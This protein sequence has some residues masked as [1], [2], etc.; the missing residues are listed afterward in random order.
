MCD[1]D[2]AIFFSEIP[3]LEKFFSILEGG[4]VNYC[5]VCLRTENERLLVRPQYFTR[6]ARAVKI[7]KY[8]KHNYICN[9]CERQAYIALRFYTATRLSASVDTIFAELLYQKKR[10]VANVFSERQFRNILWSC[11]VENKNATPKYYEQQLRKIHYAAEYAVSKPVVV[12]NFGVIDVKTP[13]GKITQTIACKYGFKQT[14]THGVDWESFLKKRPG[15]LVRQATVGAQTD[16]SMNSMVIC[17][18]VVDERLKD[19]NPEITEKVIFLEEEEEETP[20]KIRKIGHQSSLEILHVT[21]TPKI[22]PENIIDTPLLVPS[23]QTTPAIPRINPFPQIPTSSQQCSMNSSNTTFTSGNTRATAQN[24]TNPQK[25]IPVIKLIKLKRPP[26]TSEQFI[27]PEKM[28]PMFKTSLVNIQKV[29]VTASHTSSTL[30]NTTIVSTVT[31]SAN[32]NEQNIIATSQNNSISNVASSTSMDPIHRQNTNPTS[33]L[34]NFNRQKLPTPTL[35]NS[36]NPHNI[37]TTP[38]NPINAQ[39]IPV[40]RNN[41]V[42]NTTS[43]SSAGF[44]YRQN[45]IHL[46]NLIP[47][48]QN[49]LNPHKISTENSV[50]TQNTP[51]TTPQNL[52]GLVNIIPIVKFN[53][54]LNSTSL[55]ISSTTQSIPIVSSVTSCNRQNNV[56]THTIIPTSQ[57]NSNLQIPTVLTQNSINAQAMST[58]STHTSYTNQNNP[59]VSSIT[60]RNCQNKINTPA[61]SQQNSVSARTTPYNPRTTNSVKNT[62]N[63]QTTIPTPHLISITQQKQNSTN[64]QTIPINPRGTNSV[65]NST[66][67]SQIIS[68][69]TQQ[70]PIKH[71]TIPINPHVTSSSQNTCNTQ[72]VFITRKI[73]RKVPSTINCNLPPRQNMPIMTPATSSSSLNMSNNIL[74]SQQNPSN[75]PILSPKIS[76]APQKVSIPF[77]VTTGSCGNNVTIPSQGLVNPQ[78]TPISPQSTPTTQNAPTSSPAISFSRQNIINAQNIILTIPLMSATPQNIPITS[79]ITTTAPQ[80]VPTLCPIISNSLQNTLNHQNTI[81]TFPQMSNT[82][83]QTNTPALQNTTMPS[84]AISFSCQNI[85]NGQN[86]VPTL[87]QMTQNIPVILPVSQNI[88][89]ALQTILPAP[90]TILPLPQTTL[91]APQTTLPAPQNTPIP[92]IFSASTQNNIPTFSKMIVNTQSISDTSNNA[93]IQRE[94]I[95]TTSQPQLINPEPITITSQAPISSPVVVE[96]NKEQSPMIVP[97]EDILQTSVELQT[98]L[99]VL[100]VCG[101]GDCTTHP[102]TIKEG[103]FKVP[104][105]QAF[106]KDGFLVNYSGT[107]ILLLGQ[108]EIILNHILQGISKTGIRPLPSDANVQLTNTASSQGLN[109]NNVAILTTKLPE[110]NNLDWEERMPIGF[111]AYMDNMGNNPPL[112][113]KTPKIEVEVPKTSP[114][115]WHHPY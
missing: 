54:H 42:N 97:V 104:S 111:I 57:N 82:A 94:F 112:T 51:T 67:R 79:Q 20:V 39:N 36:V 65:Q 45:T 53:Q 50:S 61:A 98:G 22:I 109:V 102:I 43:T 12:D 91:S 52:S 83:S 48:S 30:Q 62:I 21:I 92:T 113:P 9:Y 84:P 3:I 23:Q 17:G 28:I 10:K 29:P 18:P 108:E 56:N 40:P 85:V 71:Q 75:N 87:P 90:Q 69:T 46:Q 106:V 76:T 88:I 37:T 86:V 74:T 5:I 68:T 15:G 11:D 33:S 115:T 34:N 95:P 4:A 64:S 114:Q 73:T 77:R 35:Q 80:S 8:W 81:P 58:M 105:L 19:P 72:K 103:V 31:S 41:L 14:L 13:E 27:D 32:Q 47:T 89:S 26:T 24:T 6:F 16:I 59:I 100:M 107:P 55:C 93:P 78:T 70:N 96:T 38:Q 99:G 7:D 60:F 110:G 49:N 1:I 66:N 2:D 63:T 25:A 44:N 101:N